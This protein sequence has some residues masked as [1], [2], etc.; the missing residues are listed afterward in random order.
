MQRELDRESYFGRA[1]KTAV[2]AKSI[3]VVEG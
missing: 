1:L 3:H 2:A